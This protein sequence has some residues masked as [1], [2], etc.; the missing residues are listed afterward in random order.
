MAV[1]VVAVGGVD[2][3]DSVDSIVDVATETVVWSEFGVFEGCRLK[4]RST[5]DSLRRG[6][7]GPRSCC[8]AIIKLNI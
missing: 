6:F 3:V 4:L 2:S 8:T 7:R 5:S 1:L